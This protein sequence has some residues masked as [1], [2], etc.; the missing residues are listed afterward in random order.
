LPGKIEL[1]EVFITSGRKAG[2]I[3]LLVASR[4]RMCR[5]ANCGLLKINGLLPLCTYRRLMPLSKEESVVQL[6][7]L[8]SNYSFSPVLQGTLLLAA[9]ACYKI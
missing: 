6:A 1:S 7:D 9:S 8:L 2:I 5:P 4:H 3:S